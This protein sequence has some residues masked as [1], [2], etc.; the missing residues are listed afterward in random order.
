MFVLLV[1]F[2][3]GHALNMSSKD[4]IIPLTVHPQSDAGALSVQIKKSVVDHEA[5]H[6]LFCQE[7]V[8]S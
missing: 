1:Q 3:H 5:F 2:V 6:T 8:L 4:F 7:K